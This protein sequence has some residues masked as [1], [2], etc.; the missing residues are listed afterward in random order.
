MSA[1]TRHRHALSA[2]EALTIAQAR[3]HSGENEYLSAAVSVPIPTAAS[4]QAPAFCLWKPQTSDQDSDCPEVSQDEAPQS[5][6]FCAGCLHGGTSIGYPSARCVEIGLWP[7][8]VLGQFIP[9][10]CVLKRPAQVGNKVPVELCNTQRSCWTM[11]THRY[12]LPMPQRSC[13]KSSS[14]MCF[15]KLHHGGLC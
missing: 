15:S 1:Q 7:T 5:A 12:R 4:T 13:H 6:G 8:R 9:L 2:G 10:N 11:S 14:R 3:R